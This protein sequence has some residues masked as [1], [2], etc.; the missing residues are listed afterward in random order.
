MNIKSSGLL[1]KTQTHTLDIWIIKRTT[2]SRKPGKVSLIVAAMVQKMECSQAWSW[3]FRNWT[4]WTS[5]AQVG[6]SQPQY[7]KREC[8]KET[9]LQ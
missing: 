6:L 7:L 8:I 2:K 3:T 5:S 9:L 1:P 4:K